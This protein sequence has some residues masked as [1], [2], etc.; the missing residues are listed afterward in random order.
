MSASRV[1]AAPPPPPEAAGAGVAVALPS[2][3]CPEKSLGTYGLPV[4]GLIVLDPI[5]ISALLPALAP[6]VSP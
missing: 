2:P 1:A 5:G 3:D 4:R 6:D